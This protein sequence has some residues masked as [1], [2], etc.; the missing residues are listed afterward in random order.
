MHYHLVVIGAG[1]AGVFAALAA[2]ATYPQA[3]VLI[4][5]KTAVCL[6][7]VRISGGGRCNV[8]HSLFDPLLLVKNYPRGAKELIAPFN[9]FGPKDMIHWL[10][11]RGV[12]L[13][14]EADGRM[15]PISDDS[16]TII[17]ALLQE[18]EKIG[19]EIQT[20]QKI[21]SIT[22]KTCFEINETLTADRLL[23]ATGNS[24]QGYQWAEQFGSTIEPP[25]P[26][27]FTFHIPLSPFKTL[28]GISLPDVELEM[29]GTKFTQRGP[30]LLTHFGF[31]G[32]AVIKLSAWSAKWLAEKKYQAELKI[33]WVPKFRTQELFEKLVKLKQ[34]EPKK[35]LYSL[36][37]FHFP[38]NFC[39]TFLELL[40]P[41]FLEPLQTISYKNLQQ[42]VDK[43]SSDLYFIDGKTTNKEEFVTCGG[44][45][46]REINFK[47]MESNRTP[48][49]FFAGE[50]LDI[51]G[52]TGGFNFQSA[53][54]TG[55]IAGSSALN[56]L[57]FN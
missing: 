6:A 38:K 40:H 53:W 37:I 43:L 19:V 39:K 14:T 27:L 1:A 20:R 13:K 26:S 31:S 7:K 8:T 49:L 28:S 23:L 36:N 55:W 42:L 24:L 41:I 12:T 45:T 4:L 54:T 16:Q 15:F 32:P 18:A 44:V 5:E 48:G 9:R 25:V 56:S 47:T 57:K 35:S 52:V 29:K 11:Q 17:D 22:K 10:E 3:K 51:D 30:L 46:L 34:E 50:I 21:Q 2:K 33:N